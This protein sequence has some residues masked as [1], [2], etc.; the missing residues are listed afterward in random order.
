MNFQWRVRSE[1]S[2]K[3]EN[4]RLSAL[5]TKAER[6]LRLSGQIRKFCKESL[7]AESSLK[8][9]AFDQ[10]LLYFKYFKDYII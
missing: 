6:I 5:Q 4:F 10:K 8:M 9:S 7:S 2:Q 3:S 1:N